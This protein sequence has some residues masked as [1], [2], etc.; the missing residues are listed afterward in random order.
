[1][2]NFVITFTD[3]RPNKCCSMVLHVWDPRFNPWHLQ[4]PNFRGRSDDSE[5]TV[6][7]TTKLQ[8]FNKRLSTH[9]FIHLHLH[10]VGL[11]SK[12][13]KPTSCFEGCLRWKMLWIMEH[14]QALLACLSHKTPDATASRHVEGDQKDWRFHGCR[15][16]CPPT[17]WRNLQRPWEKTFDWPQRGSGNPY[18][19]LQMESRPH[20]RLCFVWVGNF[21]ARLG[22]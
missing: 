17:R 9:I 11:L 3:L 20:S 16:K 6:T 7:T 13:L 2:N 4:K 12:T 10:T 15:C 18:S 1:M 5:V 22:I 21:W 19:N 8:W 14:V